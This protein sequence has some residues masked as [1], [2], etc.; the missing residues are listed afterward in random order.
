LYSPAEY[1][2]RLGAFMTLVWL[3][4]LAVWG[5]DVDDDKSEKPSRKR[6]RK[7]PDPYD[8]RDYI[9][10]TAA[11]A[12]RSPSPEIV[13][14]GHSEDDND[15]PICA[16]CLMPPSDVAIISTCLHK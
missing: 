10:L 11:A 9:D 2:G 15:D 6:R 5:F 16:I 3:P 12:A 14:D 4:E 1:R 8:L 7:E 13:I